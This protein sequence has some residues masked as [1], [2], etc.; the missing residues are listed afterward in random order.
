MNEGARYA[1]EDMWRRSV[2]QRMDENAKLLK[3]LNMA[4]RITDGYVDE[5]S[6]MYTVR[7][8]NEARAIA[9]RLLRER[10]EAREERYN[11][12]CCNPGSGFVRYENE[13]ADC[14]ADWTNVSGDLMLK[15]NHLES[16]R[17]ALARQV[18]ELRRVLEQVEWTSSYSGWLKCPWCGGNR[19]HEP[20]CARQKA[21]GKG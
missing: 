7:Q 16:D 8:R 19:R 5:N 4:G 12:I 6:H 21:L 17:D 13:C 1:N 10:D 18:D 11:R 2:L 3:E 14:T 15:V 20:D 9:R